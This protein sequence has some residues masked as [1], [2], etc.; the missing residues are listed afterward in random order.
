VQPFADWMQFYQRF[1][2][3]RGTMLAAALLIG[4]AS[5]ARSWTSGGFGRLRGWGGPALLPWVAAMA[6]LLVPNVTADFSERYVVPALP[7]VCIAAAFA[8]LP[9]RALMPQAPTA[10]AK[11]AAAELTSGL[12]QAG[13]ASRAQPQAGPASRA[14]LGARL[15]DEPE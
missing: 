2:Y 7:V 9:R 4:L 8:F 1:V 3:I 6:M 10:R 13:P 14:Q 11:P 5:I 12:P 15:A